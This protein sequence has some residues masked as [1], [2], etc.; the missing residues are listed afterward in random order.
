MNTP[1]AA[2]KT[3]SRTRS[4]FLAVTVFSNVTAAFAVGNADHGKV[5]FQQSCAICHATNTS[6]LGTAG[7]GPLLAGVV[8]R[9]AGSLETFGYTKALQHSNINWDNHTLDSFLKNPAALVPGTAMVVSVPNDRDRADVVAYLETLHQARPQSA[10][11][12]VPASDEPP[13]TDANSGDWRNDH[14]GVRHHIV[15][16]NLPAP[17]ATSSAGNGARTVDRPASAQLSVPEGFKVDLFTS[18]LVGPRSVR[19]APNG[20]IFITESSAGRI[21]VIRAADGA[22]KPSKIETFASGLVGPWGMAFYPSHGEPKYLY[23][24]N[25][26]AVVR[27]PYHSGDLKASGEPENV[28]EKLADTTGGHTTRDVAFSPD[29][30]ILY[31]AVGSGSNVAEEMSPREV[32]AAQKWEATQGFGAT[33]GPERNRA[34]VLVTDPEGHEPVHVFATGIRNPVGLAINPTTGE[35]WASTNERDGLGDDLVPDYITHV[36]EGGYYGWPWYYLGNHEDPRH[37]GERPDLAGKAIVPDVLIQAHSASLEMV[38]YPKATGPAAF[39]EE[40]QGEAFSALHGS[41]N[42]SVR[43]GSKVVRVHFK[44]GHATGTYEDFLTGFVVNN[45]DVWGRPSGVAVAHDGALL[46]VDDSNNTLWRIAYVGK[47]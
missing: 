39:P 6:Q 2:F 34:D 15:L 41:W 13:A 43:T 21:R 12:D 16:E 40:Y 31:I 46:V 22:D 26:N 47:N 38:F 11:K 3:S 14:P 17:F 1:A 20:D 18:D 5:L 45:H 10:S 42:R 32:P 30:K 23:V 44:D 28:V 35:L 9:R 24:G 8:G 29:D 36:R 4:A 27:F 19:V 7:Q 33:W 25:R 37:A